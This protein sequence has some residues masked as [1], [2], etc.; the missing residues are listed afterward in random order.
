MQRGTLC[1]N[2]MPLLL[3]GEELRFNKQ[4]AF[5]TTRRYNSAISGKLV[6]CRT[7]KFQDLSLSLVSY[8]VIVGVGDEE[9]SRSI[10]VAGFIQ[11]SDRGCWRPEMWSR[12]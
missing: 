7:K 3:P 4:A 9:N 10:S 6:G 11:H 2:T 8:T 5:V 12:C 1:A